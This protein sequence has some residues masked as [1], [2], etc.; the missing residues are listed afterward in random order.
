MQAR[1]YQVL[2]LRF[3]GT[4]Q[5]FLKTELIVKAHTSSIYVNGENRDP[6]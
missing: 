6:N 3:T 1:F 2:P 5:W 4:S